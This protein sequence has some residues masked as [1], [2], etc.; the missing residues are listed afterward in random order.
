MSVS[1]TG[2]LM[3]D[4]D[5][6]PPVTTHS[7]DPETPNGENG[8]YVSDVTVTLNATDDMSGVKEIK[9]T[10]NGESGNISGD[11]GSFNVTDDGDDIEIEYWAIDNAGNVEDKNSFT[12]DIDPTI[13]DMDEPFWEANKVN[14]HW[15][16]LFTCNAC[17][18]TS[19]MN[20]TEFFVNDNLRET[21]I[22]PGPTY[23]WNVDIGL[24]YSV[25]GLI[26]N[27][28]ISEEN[29]SFFA[30]IVQIGY[31]YSL[32]PFMDMIRV[33]VYDNAGNWD[34]DDI[35][36]GCPPGPYFDCFQQFTF[37]N[38]Y[39]GYIGKFFI[40]ATFVGDTLD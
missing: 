36:G 15:Y 38:E 28:K 5:T 14:G 4:D 23:E 22:G 1:S 20:R 32:N 3:S 39:K 18:E 10:I 6:T 31:K 9:Y 29:V 40:S 17:D 33:I 37:K 19:G 30:L 34:Y 25:F 27:R 2:T 13:P 35:F 11:T 26:C 21:V 7:L 16:I 12:L 8:W 24:N